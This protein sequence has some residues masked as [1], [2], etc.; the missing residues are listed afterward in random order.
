MSVNGAGNSNFLRL[1]V[2]WFHGILFLVFVGLMS[3]CVPYKRSVL[4]QDKSAKDSH[5]IAVEKK[6]PLDVETLPAYRV[7]SGDAIYVQ[8]LHAT[9]DM[10]QL[11][12]E[13]GG[14]MQQLNNQTPPFQAGFVIDDEGYLDLPAIG[15][16]KAS[17]NT[18]P[19]LRSIINS[20]AKKNLIGAT[21]RVTMMNFYVSV[22]GEVAR[23]GRFIVNDER[24]TVM[25]A[26]GLGGGFDDYA[27]REQVSIMRLEEDGYH[28]YYL[29]LTDENVL[30]ASTFH[31]FP[32]DVIIV[33][34]LGRKKIIGNSAP[35]ITL[36][37]LSS[38]ITAISLI[39]TLSR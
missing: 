23:P 9:L 24:L 35:Q 8:L 25:D 29:D 28:V 1:N 39:I 33:R 14:T 37:F 20:A 27:N 22:L 21:A 34:P 16:I 6:Y 32:D 2:G 31:V 10:Q 36:T 15:K 18:L 7:K 26:L 11:Y 4:L 12:L 38:M 19:E 13:V 17:G 5:K 3:S 30:L